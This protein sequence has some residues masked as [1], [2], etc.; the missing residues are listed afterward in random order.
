MR[1][2]A[3]R[4]AARNR[5]PGSRCRQRAPSRRGPFP[6]GRG[7][8]ARR[9]RPGRAARSYVSLLCDR[10]EVVLV[11]GSEDV[12]ERRLAPERA[13]ALVDVCLELGAEAVDIARDRHRGRV[14]ERAEAFAEDAVADVEQEVEVTLCRFAV[15]D[16][17]EEL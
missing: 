13:A 15:L 3:P 7:S 1:R 16:L 17:V 10:R 2:P 6:S 12:V 9:R 4:A 14:A 5:K 11:D 8:L